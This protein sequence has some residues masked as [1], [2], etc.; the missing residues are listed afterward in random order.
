MTTI[1]DIKVGDIVQSTVGTYSQKYLMIDG[2][3]KYNMTKQG[4]VIFKGKSFFDTIIMTE[5]GDETELAADPGSSGYVHIS[6]I[7]ID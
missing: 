4:T 6:I 5:E 3:E 7:K 1:N 2:Y